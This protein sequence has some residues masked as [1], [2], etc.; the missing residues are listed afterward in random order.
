[1][2]T[3]TQAKPLKTKTFDIGLQAH[4]NKVYA[5]MSVG[6][7]I[8]FAVAWAIGSNAGAL[9]LLMNPETMKP[10]ILGYIVMFAPLGM[11]MFQRA[12]LRMSANAV[13]T[14]FYVFSAVMGL[15]LSWI[16]SAYTGMSIATTFL[17]T[18][19]SFAALSLWGYSTKKDISGWGSFLIMGLVGIIVASIINL[20][21]MSSALHFAV[22]ILGVFIFAG[23]TA[24]DTQ[25][26]KQTYLDHTHQGDDEWLD[27]AATLGATELYLDFI[28]LMIL[29]L[30]I[31]GNRK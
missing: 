22:T 16:F 23:L 17:T 15:S 5:V 30:S 9:S 20:F 31:F 28:N 24:Y 1:M 6:L 18:S 11:I 3:L 13:R 10:N 7:M 27:K 25:K 4:M 21:L 26:I 12:V 8:T 29:L 19:I 14:F 2:D